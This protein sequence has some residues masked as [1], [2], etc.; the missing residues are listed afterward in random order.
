M[1]FAANNFSIDAALYDLLQNKAYFFQGDK[2]FACSHRDGLNVF[3]EE[4][5]VLRKLPFLPTTFD[6]AYKLNSK[7]KSAAYI[8]V[9]AKLEMHCGTAN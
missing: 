8:K 4:D 6:A 7:N 3:E 1:L 5:D 2:Y 9:S